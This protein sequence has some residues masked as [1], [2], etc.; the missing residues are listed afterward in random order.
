MYVSN[1]QTL[2]VAVIGRRRFYD[3]KEFI[4]KAKKAINAL[5]EEDAEIFL[6]GND[7]NFRDVCL[8]TVTELKEKF[9]PHVK[10]VYVKT[11]PECKDDRYDYMMLSDYDE[12]LSP[13]GLKR[14]G[15]SSSILRYRVMIDMC[16]ILLTY[17]DKDTDLLD[18]YIKTTRSAVEYA[19]K[20]NK[21]IININDFN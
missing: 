21:K 14:G 15:Y 6:F 16:D 20:L 2:T 9:Y 13:Y 10:R 3:R 18:G 8:M 7:G 4:R 11:S 1:M 19:Q 17:S 5:M 12:I